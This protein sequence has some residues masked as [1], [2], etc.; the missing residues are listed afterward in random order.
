[1]HPAHC[2]AVKVCM[3][4]RIPYFISHR[5]PPY[6]TIFSIHFCYRSSRYPSEPVKNYPLSP[7]AFAPPTSST[8]P[9]HASPLA[10]DAPVLYRSPAYLRCHDVP[11]LLLPLP[12]ISLS[13]ILYSYHDYFI[14]RVRCSGADRGQ[15]RYERC[16]HSNLECVPAP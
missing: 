14:S 12:P 5:V 13:L 4:L 16:E 11:D 8:H 2:Q 10:V 1:M 9:M 6:S 7:S 3:R 15:Q